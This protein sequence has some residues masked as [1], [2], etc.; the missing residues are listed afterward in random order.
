MANSCGLREAPQVLPVARYLE[1][2]ALNKQV[3]RSR[4]TEDRS[5]L[6]DRSAM[7]RYLPRLNRRILVGMYTTH[8]A[9]PM[10]V[11]LVEDSAPV[12]ERLVEIIEADGE[13]VVVGQAE[14]YASAVEGITS[15]RP[16]VG[17]FDIR[18]QRGSGIDALAEAKRQL[19]D[20]VGIVM[21]NHMTPQHRR[22]GAKAG[23]DY[24]LDKCGDFERI[25]DI[26]S[27]LRAH[28]P[29]A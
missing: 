3:F 2:W 5:I 18:L 12:R 8:D 26:L 29:H 1:N 21:S 15:T 10:K 17:I 25:N 7:F 19:P 13:W 28:T 22:A 16:D 9:H 23:A 11:F 4:P 24:L 6:T 27:A 20:L 14:S